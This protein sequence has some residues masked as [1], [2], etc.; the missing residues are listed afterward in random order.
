MPSW[1][2]GQKKKPMQDHAQ[3]SHAENIAR[4]ALHDQE[5]FYLDD[6]G[7]EQGPYNTTK[8]RNWISR[9]YLAQDRMFW[10]ADVGRQGQQPLERW[11]DLNPAK[12]LRA[13]R[14]WRRARAVTELAMR[15]KNEGVKHR[16]TAL[17]SNLAQRDSRASFGFDATLLRCVLHCRPRLTTTLTSAPSWACMTQLV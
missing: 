11:A 7:N 9:G 17:E 8:V 16:M 4:P 2:S 6:E 3:G 1:L 13:K 12:Y 5:W 10:K 15:M 14:H